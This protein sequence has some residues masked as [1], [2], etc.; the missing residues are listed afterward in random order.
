MKR[1]CKNEIESQ[2]TGDRVNGHDGREG[3]RGR[4]R[5]TEKMSIFM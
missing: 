5:F 2:P 1:E 4:E 3:G